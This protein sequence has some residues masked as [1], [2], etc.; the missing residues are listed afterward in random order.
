[1]GLPDLCNDNECNQMYAIQSYSSKI[2]L[3]KLIKRE[4]RPF[5]VKNT[6]PLLALART[7][8]PARQFW[9]F[10]G[11]TSNVTSSLMLVANFTVW[12]SLLI[13]Q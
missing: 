3:L 6:V 2:E 11:K 1:M 5:R 4:N 13:Q 9:H 7:A 8:S 12:M 10:P